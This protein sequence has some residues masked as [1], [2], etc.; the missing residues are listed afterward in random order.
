MRLY[1][2]PGTGSMLFAILIGVI[3]AAGFLIRNAITKIKFLLSGGK[4]KNLGDGKIPFVIF[5]DDKRYWQTFEPICRELDK[6]GFDVKY[7]TAS[8]DDAALNN[9]Y[10]H[11]QAEFIGAGNK[12]FAKLNFLEAKILFATTPGL[13]VYQW[14]RSK[15][16]DYYVHIMHA[17]KD[18]TMYR[19]FGIDYYDSILLNG[20]FQIKQVRQLEKLRDLPK[21]ELVLAGIPYMDDMVTKFE[22]DKVQP[23]EVKNIL[24]APSWGE[25]AILSRF[26]G[27]IISA[28]LKSQYN[29]IIRPHPQSV[30][31]EKDMLDKLMAEFPNSDRLEWNYDSDNYQVLKKSDVLI[32]DFSGVLFEFSLVYDRPVL[33]ANTNFDSSP[34]DAWW[35]EEEPWTFDAMARLGAEIKEENLEQLP[36]IL[37]DCINNPKF[38]KNRKAVREE[39]WVNY[40]HGAE[41]VA[42][43]FIKKYDELM[44]KESE[45][46]DS[47]DKNSKAKKSKKKDSKNK[48]SKNQKSKRKGN[49]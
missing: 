28:L 7:M 17:P 19:M 21:K 48:K 30:A 42:D 33:F 35:L 38:S 14:K 10:E 16:V 46:K 36:E 32:S 13:D 44:K 24:L 31:S 47:G 29:I 26:G 25:S 1:I 39:I 3:G 5:S 4:S 22:R 9:P 11:V 34:Y 37:D 12:A 6:R 40:R 15:K 27:K 18:I 49:K 43:Y 23:N 8:E 41:V 20:K 45:E 2:D